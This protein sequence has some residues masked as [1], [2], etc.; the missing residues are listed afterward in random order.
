MTPIKPATDFHSAAALDPS[1]ERNVGTA[2]RRN[3]T[4][5]RALGSNPRIARLLHGAVRVAPS[6]KT[7]QARQRTPGLSAF[8]S[9]AGYRF[10]RVA[11]L[12]CASGQ[13]VDR[14][15]TY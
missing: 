14:W 7:V 4:D 10:C 6:H 9:K 8:G 5:S 2:G 1:R 15:P 3:R 11:G 13:R 12:H